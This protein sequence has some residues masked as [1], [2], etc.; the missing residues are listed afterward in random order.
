MG[1]RRPSRI[2]N[3][4]GSGKDVTRFSNKL[5]RSI[6]K[7]DAQETLNNAFKIASTEKAIENFAF[8]M[9]LLEPLSRKLKEIETKKLNLSSDQRE[10]IAVQELAKLEKGKDLEISSGIRNL[11]IRSAK[12]SLRGEKEWKTK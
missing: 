1:G 4:A 2:K 12:K 8:G 11:I 6:E 10:K 7:G 9:S 3:I 5:T